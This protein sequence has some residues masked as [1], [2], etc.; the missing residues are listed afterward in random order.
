MGNPR[1]IDVSRWQGDFDWHTRPG[2]A[3]GMCKATEGTRFADPEL[4]ANWDKMWAYQPDHRMP[5]FAY[6]FFHPD[7]DPHLQAEFFTDAV[8]RHGLL[9][10]DNLVM[11]LE[12]TGGLP[13]AGVAARGAAFL[14]AVNAMAE[15]HRVLVY[16]FPAF[17][18]AGNC[19]GMDPWHLWI[20][21]Y[22]VP[23]PD[24][25]PPWSKWAMWQDG[26]SP[27]DTDQ[28][29]GDLCSLLAFTRM[30]DKR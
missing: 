3:F 2:L 29:N 12:V 8:K 27:V 4:G 23:A 14:H 30:P 25:P 7:Q 15:G 9:P 26:D 16:T 18:R 20:A 10:G 13:A 6:H 1:G 17:A 28:Y 11:D 21:N 19:A 5:R 24:V 22:G